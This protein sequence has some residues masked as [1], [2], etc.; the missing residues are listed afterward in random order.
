MLHALPVYL[1]YKPVK[2]FTLYVIYVWVCL[3]VLEQYCLPGFCLV[4]V[5]GMDTEDL[6]CL[7]YWLGCST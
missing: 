5:V 3:F 4:Q 7:V 6:V 2:N 1:A